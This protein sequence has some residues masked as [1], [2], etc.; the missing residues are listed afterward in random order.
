MAGIACQNKRT[1]QD[2]EQ[3]KRAAAES[4]EL[5]ETRLDAYFCPFGHGWHV[6][7]SDRVRQRRGGNGRVTSKTRNG[8]LKKWQ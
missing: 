3:A 1:Y 2:K 6:G 4:S 5:Y 8:G 7:R